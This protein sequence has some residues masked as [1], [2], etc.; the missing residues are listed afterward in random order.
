M[1][2]SVSIIKHRLR[3][4]WIVAIADSLILPGCASG[5]QKQIAAFS[6]ATTMATSNVSRAFAVVEDKHY[7]SRVE[8]LVVSYPERG[9]EP[10]SIK[11]FLNEEDIAARS[12]IL[13]AL[14]LYAQKLAD[15]MSDKQVKEFDDQKKTLEAR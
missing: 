2:F 8:A 10:G 13:K 11:P 5:V 4:E 15:V 1:R 3:D 6:D 9:Y 7:Q 12:S 14:Q